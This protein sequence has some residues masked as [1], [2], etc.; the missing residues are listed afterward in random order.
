IHM[1]GPHGREVQD[2]ALVAGAEARN[3][4]ASSAHGERQ[5]VL[6]SVRDPGD[7]VCH[8]ATHQYGCRTAVDHP[9]PHVARRTVVSLVGRHQLFAYLGTE[10]CEVHQLPPTFRDAAMAAAF[11]STFY[12]LH[13]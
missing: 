7:D 13:S 1:H 12:W 10:R 6:A 9:V 2:Q 11:G 4:M 8:A 3:V 5:G